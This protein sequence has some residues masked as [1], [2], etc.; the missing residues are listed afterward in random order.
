[1]SAETRLLKEQ[2]TGKV[3]QVNT[4]LSLLLI[5]QEGAIKDSD[6]EQTVVFASEGTKIVTLDGTV[7]T[8]LS[9]VK[10]GDRV[11]VVGDWGEGFI[12]AQTIIILGA[13]E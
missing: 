10:T 1:M 4:D 2:V 11:V 9:R 6:N 12:M 8:R 7:S 3:T 5:S 13:A